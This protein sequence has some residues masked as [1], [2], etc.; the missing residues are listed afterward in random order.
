[1][2]S[3][4]PPKEANLAARCRNGLLWQCKPERRHRVPA[5]LTARRPPTHRPAQYAMHPNQSQ[6][7]PWC[8]RAATRGHWECARSRGPGAAACE[9]MHKARVNCV[10]EGGEARHAARQYFV[11]FIADLL[12]PRAADRASFA[13]ARARFSNSYYLLFG[14]GAP[15]H[16]IDPRL[17]HA[18]ALYRMG[19]ASTRATRCAT[20]IAACLACWPHGSWP[21]RPARRC[22]AGP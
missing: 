21:G 14:S 12:G 6:P 10:S 18:L 4:A 5:T 11:W 16:T 2:W 22:S 19:R 20:M 1:M 13:A 3:T 7:A 15:D 17:M 9:R 8:A